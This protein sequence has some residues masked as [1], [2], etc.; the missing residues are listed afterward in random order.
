MFLKAWNAH[1]GV[2]FRTIIGKFPVDFIRNKE[3]V[4]LLHYFCKLFDLLFC[5]KIPGWISRVTD[6]DGFGL[7]R[8]ELFE[9]RNSGQGET[10]FKISL[11][12]DNIYS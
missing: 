8:Y 4:V 10:V 6:E 11:Y 7:W 3:Q 1:D 5:I 2:M 9:F 12:R